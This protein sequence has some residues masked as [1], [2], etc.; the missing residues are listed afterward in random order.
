MPDL[1]DKVAVVTGA[2]RGIGRQAALALA[3]RGAHVVAVGRTSRD[4]PHA[5]LPG[6]VVEVA[7]ALEAW[8][9]EAIGVQ[10]DLSDEAATAAIIDTT[11]DRFG[12]ADIVVNN[13][14]YTSNGPMLEVPWHRWQRAFRVQ[15][16]AP[17]QLATGFLPGMI[18]RGHGAICNVSSGVSQSLTP[19]LSLYSTTKLAMERWSDYLDL[20]LS[21][22][23]VAV[24]TLRV[25][26][27]V[28]TEGWQHIADT[29][30]VEVASGGASVIEMVEPSLVGDQIAWMLE[31]ASSWTGNTL[32]IDEVATLGGPAVP[33]TS[34]EKTA[35]GTT[36]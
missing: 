34:N 11:L 36:S 24:N 21:G 7:E 20:E 32:G 22:S 5:A 33:P 2:T 25:D 19:G 6:S 26:R 29:Q 3:R 10:A 17:L 14:A 23:G 30:G 13:A 35:K 8:G 9:I 18:E 27:L 12:R 31:Q 4:A 16:V 1:K 15:V 28:A